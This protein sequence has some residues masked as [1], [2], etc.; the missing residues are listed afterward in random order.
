MIRSGLVNNRR[1]GGFEKGYPSQRDNTPRDEIIRPYVDGMDTG[2]GKPS[3]FSFVVPNPVSYSN[4]FS[5]KV[6]PDERLYLLKM[7]QKGAAQ[8]A[9]SENRGRPKFESAP[10]PS[11]GGGGMDAP[12]DGDMDAPDDGDMETPD[13]GGRAI[14][15]YSDDIAVPDITDIAD[16]ELQGVDVVYGAIHQP[17]FAEEETALDEW[18]QGD[19]DGRFRKRHNHTGDDVTPAT[20]FDDRY[21]AL[22]QTKNGFVKK[23]KYVG[24]D[25]PDYNTVEP[26]NIPIAGEKLSTEQTEDLTLSLLESGAK[27][28]DALGELSRGS[29]W[30]YLNKADRAKIKMA[31][32]ILTAYENFTPAQRG[33]F[34]STITVNEFNAL[35]NTITFIESKPDGYEYD[36]VMLETIVELIG[37]LPVVYPPQG[38]IAAVID[39][40]TVPGAYPVLV[41]EE[42]RVNGVGPRARGDSRN[43]SPRARFD[44]RAQR[45]RRNLLRNRV[46]PIRG[47]TTNSNIIK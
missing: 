39:P 30:T 28:G 12:D 47:Q 44:P 40:Q 43:Q 37:D 13:D 46:E 38:S 6:T 9:S 4:I 33:R 17:T 22:K 2:M 31:A 36:S 3:D 35:A 18:I 1:G 11:G 32:K 5:K 19:F 34:N 8:I 20:D 15:D 24:I 25:Y 14:P 41:A 29:E 23:G 26:I 16:E 21:D 45:A 7:A 42:V 27:V 10:L